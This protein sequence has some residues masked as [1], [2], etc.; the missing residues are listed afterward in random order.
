MSDEP[1]RPRF[2]HV[3]R[4]ALIF[5]G[6]GAPPFPGE[7]AVSGETIALIGPP[8]AIP[9]GSGKREHDLQGR[10]LA[11]GFID[12]HTHDDRIVLDAP[13][14]LPK[15][16]QGVTTVVTRQLRHQPRPVT[17]AGEPPAPMNLLGSRAAYE[18]PSLP[19]TPRLSPRP[20][21]A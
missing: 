16:S 20:C 11:P 18:F 6:T 19:P 17:F 2:D 15:I 12:A 14:M 7:L 8:G 1:G 21:P 3:F 9:P 5:D 13:D 4:N 10:A